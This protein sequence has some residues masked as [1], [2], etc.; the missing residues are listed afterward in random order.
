MI[1]IGIDPGKNGSIVALKDGKTKECRLAETEADVVEFVRLIMNFG[2]GIDGPMFCLLERMQP[3]PNPRWAQGETGR[4]GIASFKI[5]CS[6]G[7]LRGVLVACGV[8]FEEVAAAKW[9]RAMGIPAVSGETDTEKKNRHKQRAQQLFP[10]MKI[11]HATADALLIAEYC[12]RI[13][14]E[15]GMG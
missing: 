14:V 15:R 4:G 3:M 10:S 1:S 13:M 12:R 9:Q 7:F 11:V 5:G 2:I 6:Y 8:P